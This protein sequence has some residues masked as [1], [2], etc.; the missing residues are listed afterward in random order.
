MLFLIFNLKNICLNNCLTG[1]FK[2]SWNFILKKADLKCITRKAVICYIL[3]FQQ[4]QKMRKLPLKCLQINSFIK[5]WVVSTSPNLGIFYS[6]KEC[7]QHKIKKCSFYRLFMSL[8]SFDKMINIST[9]NP[10]KGVE[11]KALT[12][13]FILILIPLI[14]NSW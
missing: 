3:P 12:R 7:D 4:S 13:K 11:I 5:K 8:R 1:K 6:L 2:F 14:Y 9:L 10:C